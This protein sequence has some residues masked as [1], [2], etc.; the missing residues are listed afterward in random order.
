MKE[1]QFLVVGQLL[2]RQNRSI[3][4]TMFLHSVPRAANSVARWFWG[5][6]HE[7]QAATLSSEGAVHPR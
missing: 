6:Q 2:R 3:E 5:R 1:S 4:L 7:G